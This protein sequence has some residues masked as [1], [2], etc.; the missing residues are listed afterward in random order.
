MLGAITGRC[1]RRRREAGRDL[2]RPAVLRRPRSEPGRTGRGRRSPGRGGGRGNGGPAGWLPRRHAPA[3]DK[4]AYYEARARAD[5]DESGHRRSGDYGDEDDEPP[6][7][8]GTTSWPPS[9]RSAGRW[10]PATRARRTGWL[11]TSSTSWAAAQ[12]RG[13]PGP[14]PAAHRGRG[15]PAGSVLPRR[16]GRCRRRPRPAGTVPGQAACGPLDDFARCSARYHTPD[17]HTSVESAAARGSAE[18]ATAWADTL[19]GRA[20]PPGTDAGALGLA[21]EPQPGDG[22]DVWADLL[23][24]GEPGSADPQLHDRVMNLLGEADAAPRERDPGLPDTMV[25]RAILGI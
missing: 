2:H 10:T 20:N 1:G 9:R 12:Q 8:P 17:C 11:L 14:G 23:E 3:A 13:D 16:P 19:Q 7:G 4:I 5:D 22:V 25:I 15:L 24:T 6:E 18:D 21:N